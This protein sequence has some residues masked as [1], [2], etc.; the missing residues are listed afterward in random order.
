MISTSPKGWNFF[1]VLGTEVNPTWPTH[2]SATGGYN[3]EAYGQGQ[4]IVSA[5]EPAGALTG[6]NQLIML[7]AVIP[8]FSSA[9]MDIL[10]ADGTTSY[11]LTGGVGTTAEFGNT[12]DGPSLHIPLWNGLCV[13]GDGLGGRFMICWEYANF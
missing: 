2:N 12:S 5:A 9:T 13:I 10:E 11:L 8:M 3:I 1:T 7:R 4:S 6:A